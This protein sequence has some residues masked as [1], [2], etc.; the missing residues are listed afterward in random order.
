[1]LAKCEEH[2]YYRSEF[3]PICNKKGKFLMDDN[4]MDR[5]GRTVTGILRHFPQNFGV[6]MDEHGFVSI[7]D[8]AQSIK[9]RKRGFGWLRE[10][11]IIALAETDAKGRYEIRDGRMRATYGHTVDVNLDDLPG[12][13]IPENL[14]YP[15]A[16]E[17]APMLIERG[18]KPTD[19]RMVHLSGTKEKAMEAG[20]IRNESPVILAIDAKRAIEDGI[21][22]KRA[23][24]AVYLTKE[25]T[26][27]YLSQEED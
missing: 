13:N 27:E 8:M 6:N 16:E 18:I 25:V 26:S 7:E 19:R 23:G 14:Y 11:H 2:G 9:R 24:K 20:L 22:I 12:D 3:C 15:A 17:E 21:P 5:I 10:E 1:M 4:E